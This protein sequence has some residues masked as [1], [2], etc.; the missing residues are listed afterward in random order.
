MIQPQRAIP[1]LFAA[2]VA[3]S[4]VATESATAT[5]LEQTIC[6][7]GTRNA[8]CSVKLDDDSLELRLDPNLLLKARRLGRWRI[9]RQDGITTH[10]CNARIDL[11]TDVVYGVLRISS[12]TGTS[13]IWAQQRIDIPELQ[14]SSTSPLQSESQLDIPSEQ[15]GHP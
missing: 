2:L 1:I 14:F 11:G 4:S 10:S 12:T 15:P 5:E 7:N 6:S 3:A 8:P 9:S 13:L